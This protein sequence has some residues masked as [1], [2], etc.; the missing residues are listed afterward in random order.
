MAEEQALDTLKS[1]LRSESDWLRIF[2]GRL[3]LNLIPEPSDQTLFQS[4][5]LTVQADSRKR[6]RQLKESLAQ[7]L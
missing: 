5:P 3:T 4:A 7:H 2:S 6:V 1:I